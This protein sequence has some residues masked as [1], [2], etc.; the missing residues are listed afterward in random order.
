MI[1][2]EA[3]INL[4]HDDAGHRSLT[5]KTRK[6]SNH[7]KDQS[8]NETKKERNTELENYTDLRS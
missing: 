4:T 3:S 1:P 7:I 8:N 6:N 5:L 2:N